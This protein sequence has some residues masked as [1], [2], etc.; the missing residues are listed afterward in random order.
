M[1]NFF[2]K[3]T[4]K[5]TQEFV[6]KSNQAAFEYAC[7]Y[8]NTSLEN[9]SHV[10]GIV[11]AKKD[12]DNYCVKLSNDID[13]SIPTDSLE[14]LLNKGDTDNI[15]FHATTIDSVSPLSKGD[16]VMYIA[17]AQL[18]MI[19]KGHMAGVIIAKVKPIYNMQ[20]GGWVSTNTMAHHQEI[21]ERLNHITDIFKKTVLKVAKK[22]PN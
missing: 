11:L 13:P 19:G 14:Q 7:A 6:F 5:E 15:C 8:L 22:F 1:F 21:L 12:S 18:A 2:K 4:P 16:I 3:K 10:L 17:P 9:E 20:Y